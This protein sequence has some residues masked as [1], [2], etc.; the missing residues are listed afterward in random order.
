MEVFV[1]P[2]GR[3]VGP[4]HFKAG[5]DRVVALTGAE[6]VRPPQTL[7]CKVCILRAWA[8]V[9]VGGGTVGFTEGVAAS[10]QGHGL[11]AIHR[12]ALECLAD[13]PCRGERI[14]VAVRALRIHINEAH[15][16]GG[17]RFFQLTVSVVALV[18]QPG[19]FRTPEDIVVWFPCIDSAAAEAEGRQPHRFESDIAGEDNK[20]T[21]GDI[22]AVLLLDRP[23]Q[24][25][26][27]V[28]VRIVRPAVQWCKTLLGSTGA[29][30]TVV[31]AVRARSVPAIRITRG[32]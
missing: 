8:V 25:A 2:A 18:A 20:V 12:H 16:H 27:L 28:E 32:P 23:H 3:V 22:A 6:T 24:P 5:A 9:A 17:Q 29:P 7:F 14:R 11:F 13:V 31:D 1:V 10:D 30:T 26:S 15:L 21:P 4:G 19:G